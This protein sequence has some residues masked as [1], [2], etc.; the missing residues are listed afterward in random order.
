MIYIINCYSCGMCIERCPAEAIYIDSDVNEHGKGYARAVIDQDKCTG[1][2]QCLDF[3]CPA[4]GIQR[5]M[6]KADDASRSG[7][8]AEGG[9]EQ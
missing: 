1:C 5:S 9:K 8:H 4:D 3:D 2:E 7:I 6:V